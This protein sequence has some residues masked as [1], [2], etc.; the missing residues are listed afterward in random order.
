MFPQTSQTTRYNHTCA[1]SLHIYAPLLSP[2]LFNLHLVHLWY[3]SST[4]I[5]YM[6]IQTIKIQNNVIQY[7][8]SQPEPP[9]SR[10]YQMCRLFWSA[11][12]FRVN[13]VGQICRKTGVSVGH[14]T[15]CCVCEWVCPAGLARVQLGQSSR[16]PQTEGHTTRQTLSE[17]RTQ[18]T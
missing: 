18:V 12:A 15:E 2:R 1:L 16:V 11:T 13:P 7:V 17:V 3:R 10:S 9:L 5:F 8:E 6:K 14:S 4:T